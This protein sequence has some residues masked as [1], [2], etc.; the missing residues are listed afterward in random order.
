MN[1][2]RAAAGVAAAVTA[3]AAVRARAAP[4]FYKTEKNEVVFD[5]DCA[6]ISLLLLPLLSLLLSPSLPSEMFPMLPFPMLLIRMSCRRNFEFQ[7]LRARYP[8]LRSYLNV[9]RIT[10]KGTPLFPKLAFLDFWKKGAL[11][12]TRDPNLYK[13]TT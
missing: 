8:K 13:N 6:N 4:G 7:S 2:N 11:G 10:K 5:K 1:F 9:C 12:L 3:A